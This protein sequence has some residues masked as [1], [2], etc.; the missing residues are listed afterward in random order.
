MLRLT[1]LLIALAF[2]IPSA[3]PGLAASTA[4]TTTKSDKPAATKK[5]PP[6]APFFA[7]YNFWRYSSALSR[8]GWPAVL[9]AR[10]HRCVG[11]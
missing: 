10:K 9:N 5:A 8:C 6:D 7:A 11:S 1:A 3:G 2:A 4:P